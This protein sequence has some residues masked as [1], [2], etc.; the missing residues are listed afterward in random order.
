MYEPGQGPS[1]ER[2][3]E[4]SGW[5]TGI[6]MLVAF[7]ICVIAFVWLFVRIDPYLSDFISGDPATVTV[8]ET[9]VPEGSPVSAPT[10]Q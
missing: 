8:T 3:P 10:G 4:H 2:A 9:V 7:V 5:F 1:H 6:S